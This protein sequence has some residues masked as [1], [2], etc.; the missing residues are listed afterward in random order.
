MPNDDAQIKTVYVPVLRSIKVYTSAP[1]EL[2]TKDT[3]FTFEI[4]LAL[5]RYK[6]MDGVP[7]HGV[8]AAHKSLGQWSPAGNRPLYDFM[9]K[10]T[11]GIYKDVTKSAPFSEMT[12]EDRA[13]EFAAGLLQSAIITALSFIRGNCPT[14]E[15]VAARI[16]KMMSAIKNKVLY[17]GSI[18]RTRSRK[19]FEKLLN[20]TFQDLREKWAA[21]DQEIS[22]AVAYV[23]RPFVDT[24]TLAVR[25]RN[26]TAV[27][28][29]MKEAPDYGQEWA[30]R[31]VENTRK[32]TETALLLGA[33]GI[34]KSVFLVLSKLVNDC[35]RDKCTFSINGMEFIPNVSTGEGA[36]L[37]IKPE[38]FIE[39]MGYTLSKK[40]HK[41]NKQIKQKV[42]AAIEELRGKQFVLLEDINADSTYKYK[43]I[44]NL[45][46]FDIVSVVKKAT[47]N[48]RAKDIAD[49]SSESTERFTTDICW[50]FKGLST[51]VL[52]I[53]ISRGVMLENQYNRVPINGIK[54]LNGTYRQ[55]IADAA[56]RLYYYP[57]LTH[58][59]QPEFYDFFPSNEA[60]AA[61]LSHKNSRTKSKIYSAIKEAAQKDGIEIEIMRGGEYHSICKKTAKELA[62]K[63]EKKAIKAI[64]MKNK[65]TLLP[66]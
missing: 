25:S 18:L 3:P 7:V 30:Q 2:Q 59:T 58:T 15:D 6:S 53:A 1:G 4:H 66:H 28:D 14:D 33:P 17:R 13:A 31:F 36:T 12:D 27:N 47:I 39:E 24:Y 55:E 63:R 37:K 51:L 65:K 22:K 40:D 5:Y 21:E 29:V 42:L 43:T 41:R 16:N 60:E 34:Q 32:D 44:R 26:N 46:T 56:I 50:L 8:H 62:R 23:K 20:K 9:I 54:Y 57:L 49:E 52:P 35:Q 64:C 45:F 19:D 10:D 48:L 38:L 61:A 11:H